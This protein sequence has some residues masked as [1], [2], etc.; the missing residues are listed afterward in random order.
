MKLVSELRK[1]QNGTF[2][3]KHLYTKTL[4]K[5][6]D[7]RDFWCGVA[8]FGFSVKNM[9][10]INKIKVFVDDGKTHQTIIDENRNGFP[11]RVSETSYRTS[12]LEPTCAPLSVHHVVTDR[13]DRLRL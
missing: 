7:P 6:N 1:N 2:D 8:H 5:M 9:I 13:L 3:I 11:Q 10:L 12:V 4:C